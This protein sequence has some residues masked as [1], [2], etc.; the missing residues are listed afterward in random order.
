MLSLVTDYFKENYNSKTI[1]DNE[2]Y[3]IIY[4]MHEDDS[5]YIRHLFI[6]R[7]DRGKRSLCFVEDKIIKAENPEYIILKLEKSNKNWD[8]MAHIYI[9]RQGYNIL[10]TNEKEIRLYRKVK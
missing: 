8:R 4:D 5:L 1:T 10:D 2:T 3:F 9:R 7:E 6:R